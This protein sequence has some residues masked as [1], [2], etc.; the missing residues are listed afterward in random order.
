MP[1]NVHLTRFVCQIDEPLTLFLMQDQTNNTI[2]RLKP[3]IL[4]KTCSR[5]YLYF[6]CSNSLEISFAVDKIMCNS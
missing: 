1:V 6:V 4:R 5:K 2:L 3:Q